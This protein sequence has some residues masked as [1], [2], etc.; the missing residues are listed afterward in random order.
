MVRLNAA[1]SCSMGCARHQGCPA[2]LCQKC[3]RPSIPRGPMKHFSNS[4]WSASA[5][6]PCSRTRTSWAFVDADA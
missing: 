4:L 1:G 6:T 5:S 3:S 2:W